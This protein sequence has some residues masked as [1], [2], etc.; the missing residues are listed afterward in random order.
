LVITAPLE[1]LC[2]GPGVL[3]SSAVVLFGVA[4][5]LGGTPAQGAS[6]TLTVTVGAATPQPF[7]PQLTKDGVVVFDVDVPSAQHGSRALLHITAAL[8][9]QVAGYDTSCTF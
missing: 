7:G 9:G 6:A 2:V 5:S 4:V 1:P 3:A 8:A